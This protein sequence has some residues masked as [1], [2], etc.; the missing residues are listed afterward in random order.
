MRT[1]GQGLEDGSLKQ[2]MSSRRRPALRKVEPHTGP[3]CGYA[4]LSQPAAPPTDPRK[5][6]CGR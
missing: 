6:G 2:R 1:T 4:W 3:R 5:P